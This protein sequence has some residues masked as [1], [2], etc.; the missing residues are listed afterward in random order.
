[1]KFMELMSVSS[2]PFDLKFAQEQTFSYQ[3]NLRQEKTY[4]HLCIQNSNSGF[5]F[6]CYM[7]WLPL[8]VVSSPCVVLYVVAAANDQPASV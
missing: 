8:K 5:F 4:W 6:I 1:M 3:H 7:H 2:G